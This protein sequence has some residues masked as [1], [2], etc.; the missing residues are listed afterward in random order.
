MFATLK[1]FFADRGLGAETS[2]V[3]AWARR[4]GHVFKRTANV[5]GF[6]IDGTL[7][8][9]PWRLEWGPPQ[10]PYI[11]GNELRA[12]MVL[13]LPPDLQM[14][15]L[16]RPLMEA[17]ERQTYEQFTQSNQTEMGAATPE[18]MRWLV[19]FPKIG[20]DALKP[21][22]ARFGG[23]SSLEGDG[24]AWLEGPLANLLVKA[25]DNMLAAGPPFVLM[26][27]RGRI[28]LRLQLATPDASVIAE[29]L[30]LFE[31]AASEAL[32]V[33]ARRPIARV[34]ST[35]SASTAWQSL[36]PEPRRNSKPAD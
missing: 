14:L 5:E 13:G 4:R 11:T 23:V 8:G 32:R 34:D 22:R 29:A 17:L 9:K 6:A 20:L 31:T 19:M 36:H 18:E 7:D 25:G 10:R 33:A 1:G 26:T 12:R 35:P 28:Y 30:D 21:V 16:S 3:S 2:A 15:L 27:L 24:L